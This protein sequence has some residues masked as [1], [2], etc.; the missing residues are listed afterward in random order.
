MGINVL[1]RQ[2]EGLVQGIHHQVERSG[3]LA[4]TQHGLG[5]DIGSAVKQTATARIASLSH[6]VLHVERI[7]PQQIGQHELGTQCQ[8]FIGIGDGGIGI[9]DQQVVET[10]S[11][12]V[13]AA[14][15]GR[16]QQRIIVLDISKVQLDL[17][18]AEL[19]LAKH[20]CERPRQLFQLVDV[21]NLADVTRGVT[22]FVV[23]SIIG[24]GEHG[25]GFHLDIVV[26]HMATLAVGILGLHRV[27]FIDREQGVEAVD[28]FLGG[29]RLI[30]LAVEGALFGLLDGG[31]GLDFGGVERG[32]MRLVAAEDGHRPFH[33]GLAALVVAHAA[34]GLAT[35]HIARFKLGIFLQNCREV[36][37]GL[38]ELACAHVQQSPVIERHEIGGVALQNK[39]KVADGL[40]VVPDLCSQQT[41]VEVCLLAGGVQSDGI[42]IIGHRTEIIIQVIFH[43]GTVD[44]V[45][46]IA[47]LQHDGA[48]HIGQRALKVMV[49]A[50][51]DFRPHDI[52]TRVVLAQCDAAVQVVECAGGVLAG[53]VHLG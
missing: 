41:A 43:I 8:G 23:L 7:G 38:T 27:V 15:F 39:V 36:V 26:L 53:E 52:G 50:G 48:V 6:A 10:A 45:T 13:D 24:Q 20:E 9:L 12:I 28:D 25:H 29:L 19:R 47:R 42:V 44:E 1:G 31:S 22:Q 2:F 17:V 35:G 49:R 18:G 4:L 30:I 16:A 3:I 51:V 34:L 11:E 33:V 40:V 5:L 37:H 21:I 32:L 14:R 46:R